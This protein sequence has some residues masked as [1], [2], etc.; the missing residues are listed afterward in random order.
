MKKYLNQE[1]LQS[2]WLQV[3]P[4]YY[5]KGIS[6]NIFQKIWHG[7]KWQIIDRL[8]TGY[9]KKILDL[10]CASGHITN[11]I[12]KK[13][14]VA[15]V[16]GIDVSK[17]FIEYAKKK[18]KNIKFICADGHK[19]PFPDKYFNLVV[20]TETLEHVLS[21]KIVM[22]EIKRVLRDDG[23]IIIEMD[24]GSFFFSIVWYLWKKIGRGKVWK[25]AH[26][27][28]FNKMKLKTLINQTGFLIT[29]EVNFNFGMAVF[30]KAIKLK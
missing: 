12:K 26:I 15:E 19:I 6:D 29:N 10:G 24:S 21:P 22:K 23:E 14:K 20:C 28:Y 17:L 16:F 5:E 30:F 27:S 3:P 18:Y 11:L 1:M 4:D 25:D 8:L 2:I 7:R 13:F 9:P